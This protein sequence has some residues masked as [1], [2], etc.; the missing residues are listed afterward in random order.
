MFGRRSHSRFTISPASE[1]VLRILNDVVV[2]Q[3]QANELIAISREPG[4]VG[5]VLAVQIMGRQGTTRTSARITES[6]PFVAEGAV[7]HRLRLERVQPIEA[8]L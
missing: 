3:S 5:E 7:R 1:G 2:Q 8:K 4:V 6:R